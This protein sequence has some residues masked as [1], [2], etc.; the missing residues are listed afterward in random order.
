[1]KETKR[2]GQSQVLWIERQPPVAS[3]NSDYFNLATSAAIVLLS[4]A[5]AT[6]GFL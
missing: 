4:S 5:A 2:G 1:M 6:I 3:F